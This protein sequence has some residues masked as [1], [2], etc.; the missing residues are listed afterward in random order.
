MIGNRKSSNATAG[1]TQMIYV[2]PNLKTGKINM[3]YKVSENSEYLKGEADV[4]AGYLRSVSERIDT[5]NGKEVK[6]FSITLEEANQP[7]LGDESKTVRHVYV[8]NSM[9]TLQGFNLLNSLATALAER[10]GEKLY[11]KIAIVAKKEKDDKGK[12]SKFSMRDG[13]KVYTY[14]VYVKV[15]DKDEYQRY[16]FGETENFA[17]INDPYNVK[18]TEANNAAKQFES[19]AP[20]EKFWLAYIKAV[21]RF[22][23]FDCFN[24]LLAEQGKKAVLDETADDFS[25]TIVDL[26]ENAPASTNAPSTAMPSHSIQDDDEAYEEDDDVPSEI[27]TDELPF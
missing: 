4:V 12:Y 22:Q 10:R 23:A 26:N 6:K 7:M 5:L 18:H 14:Q 15:G 11:V 2:N 25:Y 1:E 3:A 8:I 9:F 17:G 16:Y 13:E 19:K 20:R 24:A 21:M 27:G